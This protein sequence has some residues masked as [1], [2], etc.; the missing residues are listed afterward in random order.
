MKTEIINLKKLFIATR[1]RLCHWFNRPDAPVE[2]LRILE[3]FNEIVPKLIEHV[4]NLDKSHAGYDVAMRRL[5]DEK[6]GLMNTIN[7]LHQKLE[8]KKRIIKESKKL[9]DDAFINDAEDM[10][11]YDIHGVNRAHG[12][13][14]G[15]NLPK[16]KNQNQS[17]T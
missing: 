7:D 8:S 1:L 5:N 10:N 17:S 2:E 12:L 11:V 4:E 13:L 14:C 3:N 6:S 16:H 15:I 9:L